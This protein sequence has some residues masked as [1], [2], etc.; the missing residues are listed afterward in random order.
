MAYELVFSISLGS[1]KVGLTLAAQLVDKTGAN[2]G[3]EITTGFVEIGGGNYLWYYDG[4]PDNHRGGV[5]F[6][7]VGAPGAI[8][9]FAAINPEE[10][11]DPAFLREVEG[12]RWKL[13][14]NQMVFYKSDNTTEL[15][16]F[17]L[18]DAAG[19]PSLVNVYE[20]KRV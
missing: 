16:R 12:G 6:Y 5:K 19:N 10:A 3:T 4:F 13:E 18:F 20:R 11:E 15:M 9:A 2:V 17:D 14:G 8:L 1:A 7:E